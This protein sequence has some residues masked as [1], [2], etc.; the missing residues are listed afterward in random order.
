MPV[1]LRVDMVNTTNLFDVIQVKVGFKDVPITKSAVV[2]TVVE[3]VGMLPT[4]DT[5]GEAVITIGILKL[6]IWDWESTLPATYRYLPVLDSASIAKLYPSKV[7]AGK[8]A[9]VN[10][11]LKN[12]A[13]ENPADVTV[14]FGTATATVNAVSHL[15]PY[16]LLQLA[17]PGMTVVSTVAVTAVGGGSTFTASTT[18]LV[19]PS[20]VSIV[21]RYL[22][23]NTMLTLGV[24]NCDI[25]DSHSVTLENSIIAFTKEAVTAGVE[26]HATIPSPSAGLLNGKVSC[27]GRG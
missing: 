24:S 22:V 11:W 23:G 19:L 3:I 26:L 1:K 10:L 5:A 21:Y 15:G 12:V 14:T 27:R 2:G 16:S 18:I 8:T 9:S 4:A 20:A 6:G 17:V 7:M 13:V 25:D